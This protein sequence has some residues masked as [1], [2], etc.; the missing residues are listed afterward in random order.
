MNFDKFSFSLGNNKERL[1]QFLKELKRDQEYIAVEGLMNLEEIK[2]ED[3]KDEEEFNKPNDPSLG[4]L[5]SN[6]KDKVDESEQKSESNL[7]YRLITDEGKYDDEEAS[8]SKWSES[9][10]KES[11]SEKKM[12]KKV[13][14]SES[15]NNGSDLS[16]SSK[17]PNKSKIKAQFNDLINKS[18]SENNN[19]CK[20][21]CQETNINIESQD[22]TTSDKSFFGYYNFNNFFNFF[23]LIYE[24]LKMMK[25]VTHNIHCYNFLKQVITL[26]LAN[27]IDNEVYEDI[28]SCLLHNFS[29]IYMNFE[30]ILSNLVKEI[31]NQ[32]VDKY[33]ISLNKSLFY[34]Q[35]NQSKQDFQTYPRN[36]NHENLLMIQTCHM[37]SYLTL[38]T[39][40]NNKQSQIQSYINNNNLINDHILKFEFRADE[41]IF[42][43]HKIK[44]VYDQGFKQSSTKKSLLN[45][46][47]RYNNQFNKGVHLDIGKISR[48]SDEMR[49]CQINFG[50]QIN[51]DRDIVEEGSSRKIMQE[52]EIK[53]SIDVF[54]L[55]EKLGKEVFIRNE[56][57]YD[58]DSKYNEFNISESGKEDKMFAYKANKDDSD[59]KQKVML[60]K[61]IKFRNSLSKLL[62]NQA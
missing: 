48:V 2:E 57:Q 12:S 4:N 53:D 14:E 58:F 22:Y 15:I 47:G 18:G 3:K 31:P 21:I 59:A 45:F 39:K 16:I 37:L 41:K 7:P 52:M 23:I 46:I 5:E 17:D 13:E 29:G 61:T 38:K 43:I 50:K 49:N 54:N 55:K 8:Y 6:M 33:V 28:I 36:I 19:L 10:K 9:N 40:A 30:K 51:D 24:R 1:M 25:S 26:N 56:I 44:S 35:P 42:V 20:E 60:K 11:N 32:D 27:I 34:N 62:N